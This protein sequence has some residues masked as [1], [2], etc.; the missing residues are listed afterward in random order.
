MEKD[1]DQVLFLIDELSLLKK[2][3]IRGDLE[4]IKTLMNNLLHK[5]FNVKQLTEFAIEKAFHCKTNNMISEIAIF[6][7][8]NYKT[9]LR[10]LV[11]SNAK[12]LR[13]T[14]CKSN[15]KLLTILCR[16]KKFIENIT[17][18][19]TMIHL[20]YNTKIDVTIHHTGFKVGHLFH[21]LRDPNCKEFTKLP[22]KLQ[23]MYGKPTLTNMCAL[24]L[25]DS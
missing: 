16:R 9:D 5:K 14:T 7:L 10:D 25:N 8:T 1:C 4:S 11:I 13:F 3:V 18:L 21:I 6:L 15:N 20:C 23:L 12:V 17:D 2:M 22:I 19:D 24:K